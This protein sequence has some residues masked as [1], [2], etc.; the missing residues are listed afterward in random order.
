MSAHGSRRPVI[1]HAMLPCC[2]AALHTASAETESECSHA[3]L[4]LKGAMPDQPCAQVTI[5][6]G[7]CLLFGDAMCAPRPCLLGVL[8]LVLGSWPPSSHTDNVNN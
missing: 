2:H 5:L 1:L 6:L 4:L 3:P 7:G 8:T